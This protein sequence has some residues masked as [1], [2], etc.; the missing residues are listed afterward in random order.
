MPCVELV[1]GINFSIDNFIV[2]KTLALIWNVI[3]GYLSL[4]IHAIKLPKPKSKIYQQ[5]PFTTIKDD[6]SQFN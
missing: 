5:L 4:H 3:V 2:K 1:E 6:L